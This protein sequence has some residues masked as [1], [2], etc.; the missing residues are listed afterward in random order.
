MLA[1]NCLVMKLRCW[2]RRL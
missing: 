1:N 2:G